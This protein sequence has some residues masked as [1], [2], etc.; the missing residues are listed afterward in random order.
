MRNEWEVSPLDTLTKT[1]RSERMARI[2]SADTKPELRVRKMLS[3]V[4]YRYRVHYAP[5]PG[6]PDIAF[7]SRKKAIWVHGCFFH[8]H[9]GCPLGRIPKTRL[10]F[11]IPKLER[12]RQRDME[13]Q[14][15]LAEIGWEYHIVWECQLKEMDIVR[16]NLIQFLG[17]TH[18]I[19]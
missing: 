14:R 19:H 3:N 7:P 4:G 6:R 2:R 5:L 9:K 16:E 13:C 8:H 18:A 1:Q 11:W 15:H 12:N 17:P 10:D